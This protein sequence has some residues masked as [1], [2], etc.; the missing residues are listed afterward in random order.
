MEKGGNETERKGENMNFQYDEKYFIKNYSSSFYSRYIIMRN[1][2]MKKE[3]NK[4][5]EPFGRLLEVGFGNGN[6]LE[7]FK[8]DFDTYGLDISQFAIE[9][10]RE[11]YNPMHFKICDI[12]KKKI[13]FDKKF[14]VIFAINIIEHMDNPEFA[15]QNVFNSLEKNGIFV[16]Y[17]PTISNIFSKIQYKIFYDVEEH[18]F[19][20]SIDSVK[21]LFR[22]I[23]FNLCKEYS[24]S[25]IPF[26]ISVGFIIRSF[27]LYF[28]VWKK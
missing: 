27:N 4:L 25:F 17:F 3:I 23:G 1:N 19:R 10:I 11:R 2:F 22:Q 16:V 9:K 24:A 8:D 18:I 20:P 21:G 28:A 12:S 13:P 14:N 7:F 15:L 6:L 5:V 26:K